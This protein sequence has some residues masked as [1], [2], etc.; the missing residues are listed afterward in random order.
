MANIAQNSCCKWRQLLEARLTYLHHKQSVLKTLQVGLNV[1]LAKSSRFSP[2][3]KSTLQRFIPYPAVGEFVVIR[4]NPLLLCSERIIE[5]L[6]G[7]GRGR[8]M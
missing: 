7:R 2:Q 1:G 4:Y 8:E 5:I 3:L 6:L